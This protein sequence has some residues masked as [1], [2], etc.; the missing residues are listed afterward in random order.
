MELIIKEIIGKFRNYTEVYAPDGFCFYD[1]DDEE[2]NYLTSI[3]TPILDAKI[4]KSKF[5]LVEGNADI[6]NEELMK[7]RE[8]KEN[9]GE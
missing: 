2:I 5:I 3:T 6:L 4:L 1:K 8:E 9:T 7:K